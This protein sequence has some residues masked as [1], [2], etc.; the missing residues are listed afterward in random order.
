[1]HGDYSCALEE[2]QLGYA[3]GGGQQEGTLQSRAP[4]K[5]APRAL[6]TR[7]GGSQWEWLLGR[8]GG[9]GPGRC[10][11]RKNLSHLKGG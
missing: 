5:V 11:P 6:A 9:F 7:V 2:R 3:P 8:G 4:S 1:M 10:P